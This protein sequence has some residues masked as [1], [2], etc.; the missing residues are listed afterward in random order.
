MKKMNRT[1]GAILSGLALL[2]MA[3]VGA[4]MASARSRDGDRGSGRSV[5]VTIRIGNV[6]VDWRSGN[7]DDGYYDSIGRRYRQD[8]DGSWRRNDGGAWSRYDSRRGDWSRDDRYDRNDQ[9]DRRD[10]RRGDRDSRANDDRRD[11]RNQSR[12]SDR[13]RGGSRR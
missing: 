3:T 12:G 2:G 6:S 11:D 10:D 9:R 13:G 4:P 1:A 8:D 7:G 5:S